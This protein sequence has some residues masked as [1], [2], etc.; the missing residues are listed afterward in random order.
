MGSM[1]PAS[2][3]IR[4]MQVIARMNVGGPAVMLCNLADDLD[5]AEFEVSIMTG[6]VDVGEADYLGTRQPRVPVTVVPGLGRSVRL[7]GDLQALVTLTREMRRRRPDVVHTHTAKAGVLGRLAAILARVPVRVHTF[8]GHVLHGYFGRWATAG[9][10]AVERVLA[11]FTTVLVAVGEQVRDDLLAAGV[12]RPDQYV[13]IPPGVTVTEPID[14]AEA[15]RRLELPA[16]VQVVAF[17]GRLTSIKRPDRLID[18][19]RRVH[20]EVPDA[21]LLVVG[22][23]DLASATRASAG[24]LGAAV[25]FLGWREHLA[26]IYAAADLVV[27]TSDNEGMPVTLIEAAM[28]GVPVVSTSVGS[29]KEVVRDGNTGVVVPSDPA[30]IANSITALL[31]DPVR[32]ERLG[33]AAA[34]WARSRFS[35]PVMAASHVST[36]RPHIGSI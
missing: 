2:R 34:A 30:A 1:P 20:A 32:R 19:W 4:V 10:V 33:A 6:M 9:I 15:R 7:L 22:E 8:H 26:E 27:L 29:A 17:I 23:G 18:A 25:R 21:I 12:G 14:G 11:R 3:P 36:Y 31:Q 24:N 16:A 13:V 28:A 5:P 35:R